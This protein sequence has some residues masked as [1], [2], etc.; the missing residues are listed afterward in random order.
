MSYPTNHCQGTLEGQPSCLTSAALFQADL[1]M[2]GISQRHFWWDP[3]KEEPHFCS[4][5]LDCRCDKE[6]L[7]AFRSPLQTNHEREASEKR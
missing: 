3:Y 1:R 5:W 4:E 7:L 6:P 2:T